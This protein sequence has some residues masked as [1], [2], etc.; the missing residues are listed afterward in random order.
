MGTYHDKIT[1]LKPIGFAISYKVANDEY[2]KNKQEGPDV[3][4]VEIHWVISSPTSNDDYW[5]DEEGGLD[6]STKTML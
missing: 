5:C 2:G 3:V 4:E 1:T 6:S